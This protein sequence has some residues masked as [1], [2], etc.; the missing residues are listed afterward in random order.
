VAGLSVHH[1][2]QTEEHWV[3]ADLIGKAAHIRTVPVPDWVKAA[4]D[5][6]LTSAAITHG[7]GLPMRNQNGIGLGR[8]HHGKSDLASREGERR[9][10]LA[11]PNC[12]RTIADVPARVCATPRAAN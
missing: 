3:I 4:V 12:R 9:P 5:L 7:P 8:G 11:L 6:W 2:Q 10:G 1:L